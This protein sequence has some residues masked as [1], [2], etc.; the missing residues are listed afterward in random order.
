MK[1]NKTMVAV[2][3]GLFLKRVSRMTKHRPLLDWMI[4]VW[5]GAR[6]GVIKIVLK[7]SLFNLQ[8][9]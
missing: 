1:W 2:A 3:S 7:I 4:V 5:E 9:V 6:E 8:K